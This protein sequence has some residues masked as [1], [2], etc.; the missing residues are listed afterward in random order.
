MLLC[1]VS[2][3]LAE[4]TEVLTASI[5]MAIMKAVQKIVIFCS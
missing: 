1:V 2:W 5:A 4:V 3:K